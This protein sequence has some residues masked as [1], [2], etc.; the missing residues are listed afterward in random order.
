MDDRR[1]AT[2]RRTVNRRQLQRVGRIHRRALFEAQLHR[3]NVIGLRAREGLRRNPVDARCC[4]QRRRPFL[5]RDVR[6]RAVLQQQTHH[7]D[8]A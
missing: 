1:P 4:H 5:G 7:L 3:F 2:I 6:I 8:V